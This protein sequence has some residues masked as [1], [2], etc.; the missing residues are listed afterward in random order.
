ML[1][2]GNNV[3]NA[4]CFRHTLDDICLYPGDTVDVMFSLD[5]NEFQNQK[6][7]QMIIKDIRLSEAEYE[8][9][10][11]AREIFAKL[12]GGMSVE[13]L[14][15]LKPAGIVPTHADFAAVYN[16]IRREARLEHEVFSI[17]ALINLLGSVGDKI[18]YVKLRFIM[19]VFSEMNLLEIKE[20]DADREIYAFKVVFT[21]TKTN[22]DN[23]NILRKLK[24][25]FGMTE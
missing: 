5:I 4:M 15:R 1:K 14:S 25:D 18:G 8:N 21:K 9:E 13:E 20:L 17:R 24:S 19:L 12:R 11:N 2:V 7:L 22:L 3:V 16:A 23:S 10:M 6:T